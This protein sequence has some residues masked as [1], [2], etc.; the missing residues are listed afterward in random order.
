MR[1]LVTG[2]NGYIGKHAVTSLLNKGAEVIA[3]DISLTDTDDRAEKMETDVFR[4][5]SDLFEKAGKPD[6]VLHLAWRD[7]FRHNSDAHMLYLSDHY[8]LLSDLIKAGIR[9]VAVM[10][11]MHEVGYWEGSI[12]EESP[13]NPLS[14]YGIA[15]DALRRALFLMTKE[16]EITVQWLRGFY[17][18]GDDER[19][20]SIFGKIVQAEKEGKAEFPFTT[21]KNLYDFISVQELGEYIAAA[22]CQTEVT[23]IINCCTGRPVSLSEQVNRFIQDHGFRIRLK[24]GAFPDRPYD[25][26]GVWGD[27]TKIQIILQNEKAERCAEASKLQEK[28]SWKS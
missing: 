16:Q 4:S 7:G 12:T 28:R 9:Q 25:S 27:N 14:M 3:A 19:S 2:A 1:V 26:P 13:C 15:K 22:V 20:S 23:G 21:G 6:A 8:R 24:Y 5:T 18:Y 10:G 17:I 11:S